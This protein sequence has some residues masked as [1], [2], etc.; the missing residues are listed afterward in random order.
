M[1]RSIFFMFQRGAWNRSRE[2]SAGCLAMFNIRTIYYW[3]SLSVR[4]SLNIAVYSVENERYRFFFWNTENEINNAKTEKMV[5]NKFSLD[6]IPV[7]KNWI[8]CWHKCDLHRTIRKNKRFLV[9]LEFQLANLYPPI[10]INRLLMKLVCVCICF[11]SKAIIEMRLRPV[12][13]VSYTISS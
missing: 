11:G 3:N 5:K 8:R 10:D 7:K 4:E 9:E 2:H 6:E 1:H 13:T 12:Q